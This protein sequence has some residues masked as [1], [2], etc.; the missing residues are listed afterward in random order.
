VSPAKPAPSPRTLAAV[1]AARD[2]RST[3]GGGSDDSRELLLAGL[4]LLTLALAGG[5][6]TANLARAD[7]LGLG[8]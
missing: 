7:R 4:A 2:V 8:G 1:S 3:S 5:L 6:L